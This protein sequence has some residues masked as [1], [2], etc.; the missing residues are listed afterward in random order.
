MEAAVGANQPHRTV[1][2]TLKP[3]VFIYIIPLK[4][5]L[6]SLSRIDVQ[7]FNVGCVLTRPRPLQVLCK[8]CTLTVPQQHPAPSTTGK[9]VARCLWSFRLA[10]STGSLAPQ[11]ADEG[12]MIS[13]TRT[14]EAS[15]SSAATPQHTSRSVTT[16]TNLRYSISSTTGAQPQSESRITCAACAAVSCGVQHEDASIGFI[17]SLQQLIFFSFSL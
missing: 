7:P 1:P 5:R 4:S 9:L 17:T 13:S 14:S 2:I 3:P 8:R 12:R 15:R 6:T 10:S 16:P 11:H